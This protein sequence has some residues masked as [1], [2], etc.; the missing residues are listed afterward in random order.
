MKKIFLSCFPAVLVIFPV[1]ISLIWHMNNHGW[2]SDDA[3]QYMSTAYQQYLAFQDGS[4]LDGIQAIYQV[5]GWRPVFF[6]V[7]ATP[8]LLLFKGSILAATGA[9]LVICFLVCQIYVYAIARRYLDSFRASLTAAFVGSCP[10][11]IY[12]SV[13]FFSEIAWLAF[14]TGFVFHLLESND[15]QKHR[16][17]A[18]SGILL[19]LAAVTRPAET[20]VIAVLPLTG[21]IIIACLKKVFTFYSV[22]L[23]TGFVILIA[24]L[25]TASAFTTQ[26]DG[27][28]VLALGI[29][30]I[31]SQLI[32][33]KS[34]GDDEP[35]IAG[36]NWF[37]VSLMTIN[38]IWWADSMPRLYSWIY[39]TSFGMIA[40][41]TDVFMKKEGFFSFLKN[42][43]STYLFPQGVVVMLLCLALLKPDAKKNHDYMKYLTPLMMITAGLLL[44]MLFLYKLTGTSDPRRI[45]I[46][47][48]FLLLLLA[49]LSLQNGFMRRTRDMVMTLII[50]LQL[51]GLFCIANNILPPFGHPLI[52]KNAARVA[53]QKNPDRHEA[54]ILRL[55]ELGVPKNSSVAVYTIALFQPQDR[56]YNPE[57][58]NLAAIT[59][60]SHLNIIYFWD[61][62]DYFAVI[63][64]LKKIGVPFL[65]IDTYEDQKHKN[66]HQP[67]VQFATAL[68]T[69]MKLPYIDPPG[70]QKMAG[71]KING[72]EQVLFIVLPDRRLM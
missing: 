20:L 5:R 64:R 40:N 55:L 37:A 69:E 23:V 66:D 65:L 48:S 9:T 54:V 71:F 70:L 12:H 47:M 61:I 58:L 15:F 25:L 43:S 67:P 35:G 59:T 50:L 1:I 17:A 24:S 52:I 33:M 56:V 16:Q 11:I 63:E 60:G 41:V 10:M 13:I 36:L 2:P 18:L 8:F 38:L 27:T 30:M 6:P 21:M 72:R 42:I 26:I 49:V 28:I 34:P 31:I 62:G 7:L 4:F 29:I 19:G 14:F 57:T 51:S 3:A 45:F 68:L 22:A 46:G 39:H 44:P 32:I 53:P